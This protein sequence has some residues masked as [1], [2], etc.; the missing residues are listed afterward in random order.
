MHVRRHL[1]DSQKRSILNDQLKGSVKQS[2]LI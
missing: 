2:L 1:K